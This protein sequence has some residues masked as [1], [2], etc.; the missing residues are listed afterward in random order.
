ML[1]TPPAFVLSQD[2]TLRQEPPNGVKCTRHRNDTGMNSGKSTAVIRAC[3]QSAPPCPDRSDAHLISDL[4]VDLHQ[5]LFWPDS[6]PTGI[7]R[8]QK[9]R[10]TSPTTSSLPALAFSLLFRFQGANPAPHS[11]LAR[12]WG[13]VAASA[14]RATGEPV[15][16]LEGRVM[17]LAV[18]KRRRQPA[19]P[20]FLD[21]YGLGG[22]M[23]RK[24]LRHMG[25]TLIPRNQADGTRYCLCAAATNVRATTE[26]GPA[27]R[28]H[29]VVRHLHAHCAARAAVAPR[30]S[31]SRVLS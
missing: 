24:P 1:S 17:N 2:Q 28:V 21:F 26:S 29:Q 3:A 8:Q 13:S 16:L 9:R 6:H 18:W 30:S 22:R 4:V 12:R 5:R 11:R 10:R 14:I 25:L 31:N 15:D 19:N 7:D 27:S 20:D 23:P